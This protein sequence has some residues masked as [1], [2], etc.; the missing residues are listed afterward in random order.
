MA[1][2]GK[3]DPLLAWIGANARSFAAMER[4]GREARGRDHCRA[5]PVPRV[6]KLLG[7]CRRAIQRMA[8]AP[9]GSHEGVLVVQPKPPR[10]DPRVTCADDGYVVP[11]IG[12]AEWAQDASIARP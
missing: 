8:H 7:T 4:A 5:C 2:D 11:N 6:C 9:V 12:D 3:D 1:R 10:V